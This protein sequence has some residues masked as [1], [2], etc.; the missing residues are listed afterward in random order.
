MDVLA[1]PPADAG[2]NARISVICHCMRELM[3]GLPSVLSEDLIPRPN[4]SSQALL[5]KLP[6][7]LSQESGINLELDQ[8]LV[9]VPKAL[10]HALSDVISTVA[11]EQSRNR[12]NAAALLTGSPSASHPIIEQWARAHEFFLRWTHLDRNGGRSAALPPDQEL[13]GHLVVVEDVIEVRAGLFFENLHALEDLLGEINEVIDGRGVLSEFRQPTPAQL[14]EVLRRIP[15]FS[16]RRAFF[17]GLNNPHWVVPLANEGM[18]TDP[19]E[20]EI[21]GEGLVRDRYWPEIDYLTRVAPAVPSDVVDVLLKLSGST[22]AWVYASAF[23][24]GASIR[25]S[26]AARL[27]PLI[28]GWKD[29]GI[30][31]RSNPHEMVGFAANLLK[32][33]QRK[34]GIAVA[35]LLFRPRRAEGSHRPEVALDEYWYEECLPTIFEALGDDALKIA[36]PWLEEYEHA[37]GRLTEDFEM[38]H[39]SRPSIRRSTDR[40]SSVEHALV[41]QIRDAAVTAMDT[42][43]NATKLMLSKSPMLLTRRITLYAVTEALKIAAESDNGVDPNH[44]D[45]ARE[46]L[47]A[48]EFRDDTCRIE[49]GELA[50]EAAKHSPSALAPLVAFIETGPQMKFEEIRARI[51]GFYTG[52]SPEQIEGRIQDL[53][54]TWKHRWLSAIGRDALPIELLP[55]LVEL[56]DQWGAIESPL[57]EADSATVWSGPNSPLSQDEM[58][59]MDAEELVAHLATWHAS[60]ASGPAP[61]HEGQ[62]S[63]LSA[64]LTMAPRL[65][66]GVGGLAERLRP[67]YVRAILRG[68]EAALKAGLQLDWVSVANLIEQVLTHEDASKF[69]QEGNDFD[70]DSDFRG[71]KKSAVRLLEE[72]VKKKEAPAVPEAAL[73]KFASLLMSEAEDATAWAEYES[74]EGET[75]ALTL[76]LNFR[77]PIRVH[78]LLNLIAH[79]EDVP[80]FRGALTAFEKTLAV[81]DVHGASRA[82][83]GE[84]LGR[85]LLAAPDW[86]QT[87]SSDL[88]GT[89]DGLTRNQQIALTTALSVH[90]YHQKLYTLLEHSMIGAIRTQ[91][92]LAAG[93]KSGTD[94][95]QRVGEWVIS[96]VILGHQTLENPVAEAFFT[97]VTPKLRGQALGRI[98][99]SMTDVDSLDER[100]RDRLAAIWDSRV[101]HVRAN[102]EDSLELNEFHWFVRSNQYEAMWWLPRLKEALELSPELAKER[103]MISK[104]IASSAKLDPRGAFETT[105]LLLAKKSQAGLPVWDLSRNAVPMVIA[106]ARQLGDPDL[107][108]QAVLLMNALGE[109]GYA[110]LENEVIKVMTGEITQDDLDDL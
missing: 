16:L 27:K 9:P 84:G 108:R 77:W 96:A 90:G 38:T 39:I 22:N 45:T 23:R 101:E 104:Q 2:E 80:W 74:Y 55:L 70:D 41:D 75:D 18:F 88:F 92:P 24:I 82:I 56:D 85:L 21:T 91:V 93:W 65:L 81:H 34:A 102:P 66:D 35:N 13:V 105:K 26:E 4:P 95:L 76:S 87:R 19:P 103:F 32:G 52:E 12:Q 48:D 62:G 69:P 44:L 71:A 42:D 20:Q 73:Q 58:S 37:A 29:A 64:L 99:W 10:A 17:E 89:A 110:E 57:A 8:D 68:W 6:L 100:I 15:T 109:D 14:K 7:L 51:A 67:T 83:L 3:N 50:R 33:G 98:A 36:V 59:V 40:L 1:A 86:I 79:G 60:N 61:S 72:L 5:Q 46:F 78:G 53:I 107:E 47:A 54:A 97:R 31:L 43:P 106:K 30:G 63:E 11:R 28:M 94:P 25:A 49:F